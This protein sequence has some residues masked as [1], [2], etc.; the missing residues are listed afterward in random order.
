ML[1]VGRESE[2]EELSRLYKTSDSKLIVL[3]GRR[4]VGKS[5]LVEKFI[6]NKNYL[7]FE[8]LENLRTAG[9][10][11]QFIE[12]LGTQLNDP[13]LKQTKLN[14]WLPLF[15]YLT[16][17]FA[18]NKKNK[19]ILFLDE[20]QWLAAGQTKL[21]SIIKKYWDIHW[22]KQNVMLIL[23]GSV[24][25]FMVK[26]VIL[27]KALY[28]RINWEL[29]LQPLNP[30]ESFQLLDNK[31]NELEIL[32]YSLI[33][34]GIPK[35][36]REIDTRKSLDQNINKLFFTQNGIFTN[37]YQRIFYSQ[38]KEHSNYEL[39]VRKLRD[40]PLSLDQIAKHLKIT[41]GGGIKFYLDNLEKALFITSYVPYD[42][43]DNSKLKKYKLTDEYLRFYLKFV[44]PNLKLISYNRQRNLFQQVVKSSWHSWLG[45]AFENFCLKNAYYLAILMGFSDYVLQWGP[46][47]HRGDDHF[48]IDLIYLR[49]DKVITLCEI[50]FHDKPISV[51]VVAEVER[52]CKLLELRRGYTLEKALIS[53]YGPDQ[54]LEEL[55][56]FDYCLQINDFFKKSGL[57]A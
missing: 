31:R 42:K 3:Y 38:F 32:L 57:G 1:F 19:Y 17:I 16:R 50:K 43:N 36:L 47:F 9:Q 24:S 34:G 20:F 26:K 10:I 51:S 44:E 30:I 13:I 5:T 53:L 41:S 46:Y 37:E 55:N 56:Y 28:G 29:C 52:K 14:S 6:H 27:S 54:S 21:V 48:Q 49:N 45:Y 7:R 25:S 2:F 12:D 4:R 8:G 33:L 18:E 35:Y 39:I 11:N 40:K 15:D 22:S 23:C